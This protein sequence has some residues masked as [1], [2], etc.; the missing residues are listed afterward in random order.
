MVG[1]QINS[2]DIFFA[3]ILLHFFIGSTHVP[4]ATFFARNRGLGVAGGRQAVPFAWWK[5]PHAFYEV[6]MAHQAVPATLSA[7]PVAEQ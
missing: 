1:V 4:K 5:V 7:L 6:G 2:F 3:T